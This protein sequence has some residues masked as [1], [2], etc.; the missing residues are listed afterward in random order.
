MLRQILGARARNE[1][2][3]PSFDEEEMQR[4]ALAAAH[5]PG[6]AIGRFVIKMPPITVRSHD[7][8]VAELAPT[9][10]R[11]LTGKHR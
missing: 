10:Q 3:R 1:G 7:D 8:L 4:A 6:V 2:N 11:Y 5:L 9:I